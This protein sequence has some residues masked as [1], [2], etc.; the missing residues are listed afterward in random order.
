MLPSELRL[1]ANEQRNIAHLQ[2]R[3]LEKLVKEKIDRSAI[4]VMVEASR[5]AAFAAADAADEL[6]QHFEDIDTH[7][8]NARK[9]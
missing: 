4:T 7:L 9:S 8:T 1:F 5:D 2:Q 3:M 6:A